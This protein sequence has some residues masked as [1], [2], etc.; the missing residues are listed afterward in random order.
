MRTM[1]SKVSDE[2]PA[3][4]GEPT[5]RNWFS[6]WS[7]FTLQTQNAFNDKAAQ[8]LLIPL[9]GVLMATVPGAGGLEYML[10]ALI[11]LPFIL[12][13]PLSGWVSDR[14]SKT[15][16]IRAAIML[17]FVVLAWIGLA[18]WQRNLWMAVAGFFMLSVE[19]VI[20]SPAKRGIVKELVGSSRLGFASGVLEMSVVLAVCAGQILSGWWFDIRL[21]GYEKTSPGEIANGWNAAFFPLMLVAAAALP[22]IAVSFGI[23]KIPAMGRRKFEKRIFWEHFAQLKE[24]WVDRRIRLSAA[25]AAFFWGFAGFL[26]LAAIQMGKEMTGGGVGF[27][28]DIAL[29]M[30]AASGGITLGGV[31]ASLICRKQIELGLVPVGGA[32]M[33]VGSLALAVTPISSIWIKVWLTLAGAGGAILLVPLNAYLQD[34]CPPE[35]RGTIIA[36]V[37]LLDC[38]AGMVAVLLQGV[39]AKTGAPY[40]LQFTLLAAIAV[41]ATSYAARILPQ[42]LV[43]MVVLGL[44]RMFYRVRVLNA[45]RIPKEGG[46]L[47]TPNHVSY[48]DA[49]ILSCASPRKVRFLMF[50]EYFS[51]PWIGRFVRLFDT[52]P[53]S[54]KRSK[55]AVR[56]AAEALEQGDL[57]CIFPEGQLSRTGCMNEFKRGFEMI[58]RKA[59]RPVLPAV[60]DG[61]WGSIFSFERKRFIYKKP[62]C[63]RYGVTVN[64]GEIIAP[65]EATADQVR[66]S[67]AALRAEAFP[68][69]APMENPMSVIGNPVTILAADPEVLGEYQAA[70][71]ELRRRSR[72]EQTQIVANAVQV[73]DV[74]AIGRGQT[75]MMEWTG[76]ASC[77][78][79][80]AIAL[81]QYHDLKLILV[82]AGVTAAAVKQLTDQ[83]GIEAYVGGQALAA[84][85]VQAG[86]ERRCY[87]FSA[88]ILLGTQSLPCLAV[89]QRVIA[90]SMPHPVAVTTTNQHQEGYRDQTW[91]RLLPAFAWESHESSIE[92]TG[93]SIDGSLEV[94]GVRLDQEGFVEQTLLS[95]EE[96]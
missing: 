29:L 53:I 4:E 21:E 75:V 6:F 87:D 88:D 13:A 1:T 45:D 49:F 40:F 37:N 18:V 95:I 60:M 9:G 2:V 33:I 56:I 48:V 52:V 19:S 67:V 55:E 28:T 32:I 92:L 62:Y 81:A 51:H 44:F 64:F 11:V 71:D 83:Y 89:K 8:F 16:V 26:N 15:S 12:F 76:L 91:G 57:V 93:A 78:E 43:R 80:V 69:R 58:A 47:L 90:M 82:G 42:H 73:G 36:G 7:L 61:L 3:I 50:D 94:S 41:V 66:N 25:G 39:L 72:S 63:L 86:L 68:E 34:V 20:L 27:G 77:R 84:A 22:T 85:C 79:V 59:N 35:K 17:Q 96:A 5:R 65:E 14:Y 70:V 54:Q 10:G 46:V 31:L 23:E 74:N 30:L 38:M 24:L